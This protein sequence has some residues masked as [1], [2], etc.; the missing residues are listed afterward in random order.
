MRAAKSSLWINLILILAFL[1]IA[2][3]QGLAALSPAATAVAAQAAVDPTVNVAIGTPVATFDPVQITNLVQIGLVRNIAEYLLSRDAR[4]KIIPQ[5]ATSYRNVDPTTWE[6]KLRPNVKFQNGED[7]NA[8]VVKFNVERVLNP[9]TKAATASY[10]APIRQVKVIDPLTV[11]IITSRPTP[12]LPALMGSYPGAMLPP[13]YVREKGAQFVAANP[14]GTGPYK[15]VEWVKDSHVTFERFDGYWGTRPQVKRI[16]YRFVPEESTRLTLIRT[17]QADIVANLGPDSA[18]ALA[19]A[20]NVTVKTVP[21]GLVILLVYYAMEKWAND[22]SKPIF[23]KRVRQALS[24]A[25]DREAIVKNILSGNGK[26]VNTPNAPEFFAS[27]SSLKP[28][29][30]DP[31]KAKQLLAEAGYANGFEWQFVTPTGGRYT[32]D[33]QVSQAIIEMWGK[34]GVKTI[35]KTMEW[36]QYSLTRNQRPPTGLEGWAGRGAFDPALNTLAFQCCT[37][38]TLFTTPELDKALKAAATEMDTA[39]REALYKRAQEIVQD[40]A[41]VTPLFQQY[42]IYA[43]KPTIDWIG[44]ADEMLLGEDI[45]VK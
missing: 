7:F 2:C 5:L 6:F 36:S 43:H 39:K 28:Y 17:G 37:A 12:H 13:K 26:I 11:Q 16:T 41:G 23:D 29:N 35:L 31:A 45:K 3:G 4:A 9:N 18:K 33:V 42:N 44:R 1:L 21:T 10:F 14:V 19:K 25:I 32:G 34:V 27:H 38:D 24:Y 22:G 40:E 30:Y 15:F 20:Q 8:D